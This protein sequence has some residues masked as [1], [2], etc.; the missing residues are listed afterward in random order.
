MS[1]EERKQTKITT[2]A[3]WALLTLA[4]LIG[5]W[6]GALEWR[7]VWWG[8][9]GAVI[10]PAGVF[11]AYPL[12]AWIERRGLRPTRALLPI[13]VIA[14]LLLTAFFFAYDTLDDGFVQWAY[15]PTLGVACWP[16]GLAIYEWVGTWLN[17]T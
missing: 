11:A 17:R 5:G 6:A 12:A 7:W 15:W 14:W 9:G 8:I 4:F 1:S 2:L 10:I 13:A 16:L 3:L